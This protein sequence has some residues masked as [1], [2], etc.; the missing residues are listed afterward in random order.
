MI[1]SGAPLRAYAAFGV[2]AGILSGIFDV[3]GGGFFMFMGI[4]LARKGWA[5]AKN[6]RNGGGAS[7]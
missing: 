2:F 3:G 4:I 1:P 5:V 6:A 7:A